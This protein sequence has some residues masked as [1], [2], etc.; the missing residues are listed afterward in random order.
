LAFSQDKTK[1]G[2]DHLFACM[3]DVLE[4]RGMAYRVATYTPPQMAAKA[5]VY[6]Q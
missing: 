5:D 2:K 1:I 6:V 4:R 3:K